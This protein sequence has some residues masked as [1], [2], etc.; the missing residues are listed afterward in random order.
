MNAVS[1]A[2][3]RQRVFD[4]KNLLASK[5]IS[6]ISPTKQ[7]DTKILKKFTCTDFTSK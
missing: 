3:T 4:E 7:S 1:R 5:S 2:N 6:K